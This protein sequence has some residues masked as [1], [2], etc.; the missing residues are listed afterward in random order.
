MEHGERGAVE[1]RGGTDD[2]QVMR[3]H[4]QDGDPAEPVKG[5][6]VQTHE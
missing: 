3:E 5:R 2:R 4:E 6:E 1:R